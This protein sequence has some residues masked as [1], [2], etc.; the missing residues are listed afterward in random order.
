MKENKVVDRELS[1]YIKE[2]YDYYRY[3]WE[4]IHNSYRVIQNVY[5]FKHFDDYRYQLN[6]DKQEDKKEI[7]WNASYYEKLIDYIK[8]I[9]AFETFNKALLLKK[10]YVVHNI[11][12]KVNKVLNEKQRR[13]I[14]IL[15]R[16]LLPTE[17]NIV[18]EK[19]SLANYFTPNASTI[20]F[21]H[22]L[23]ENYQ[24]ILKQDETLVYYLKD[25]NRKRNRLHLYSDFRGAFSVQDHIQKWAT[26]K[27]L[28]IKTI[29]K[30]LEE[31]DRK[32]EEF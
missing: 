13:G 21:S 10:G 7:Y 19:N 3:L 31:I 4:L 9:V 17:T 15:V 32:L 16:E 12:H 5:I 20:N 11:N 27:D 18:Y 23:N 8:I 29:W 30:E 2:G 22:L 1:I 24:H 28:C 25:I 26:I 6:S 14:P